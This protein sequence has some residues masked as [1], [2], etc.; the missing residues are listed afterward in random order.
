MERQHHDRTERS[1][2]TDSQPYAGGASRRR[3]T[4]IAQWRRDL[5]RAELVETDPAEML[6]DDE[7]SELVNNPANDSAQAFHLPPGQKQGFFEWEQDAAV[8]AGKVRRE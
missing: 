1:S 6:T 8:P 7:V 3:R 2:R 5:S 4:R